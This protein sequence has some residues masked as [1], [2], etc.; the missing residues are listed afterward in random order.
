MA[1]RSAF[2]LERPGARCRVPAGR[3]AL[4]RVRGREC[5]GSRLALLGA[6]RA[7][8]TGWSRRRLGMWARPVSSVSS[9]GY[10]RTRGRRRRLWLDRAAS[11]DGAGDTTDPPYRHQPDVR[12][13][14]LQAS[15][16]GQVVSVNEPKSGER[17]GLLLAAEAGLRQP[18]P[19]RLVDLEL[20]P[21]AQGFVGAPWPMAWA[22][23]ATGRFVLTRPGDC[24]CRPRPPTPP[25]LSP[26]LLSPFGWRA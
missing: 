13:G 14:A 3:R 18:H 12:K 21:S 10:R 5:R 23:L 20:L 11:A 2:S 16:S 6:A 22:T 17:L 1:S 8:P 4:G 7:R 24:D 9:S 19:V 15:A 25:A 26:N